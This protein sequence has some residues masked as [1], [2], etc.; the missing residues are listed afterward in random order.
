MKRGERQAYRN[1]FSTE[2][3]K[4]V[5]GDLLNRLGFYATDPAAIH[6]E[7]IA[8]ANWLLNRLGINTPSNYAQ[9]IDK[10]TDAMSFEDLSEDDDENEIGDY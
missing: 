6:P 5:L 3:G 10:L 4:G 9:Y 1:T 8:V 2:D 7:L